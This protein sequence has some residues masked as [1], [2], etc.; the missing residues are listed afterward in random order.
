MKG[1]FDDQV[2]KRE[3]NSQKKYTIHKIILHKKKYLYMIDRH[4]YL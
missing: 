2:Q 3:K 4:L 1:K